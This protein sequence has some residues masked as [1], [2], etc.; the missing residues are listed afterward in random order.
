V[1]LD[2]YGVEKLLANLNSPYNRR[3]QKDYPPPLHGT[4]LVALRMRYDDEDPLGQRTLDASGNENHA[5]FV[6]SGNLAVG[7]YGRCYSFDGVT[8]RGL[9]VPHSNDLDLSGHLTMAAWVR[10]RQ[11]PTAERRVMGRDIYAVMLEP[12]L[13]GCRFKGR[14]QTSNSATT[15][16]VTTAEAD[17]KTWQWTHLA[18][19]YDPTAQT[20][21]LYQDLVPIQVTRSG[22]LLA[23][24]SDLFLGTDGTNGLVM[25]IKDFRLIPAALNLA[26]LTTIAG[27]EHLKQPGND[28]SVTAVIAQAFHTAFWER[29]YSDL[30]F[31][32]KQMYVPTATGLYLDLHGL[33]TRTVRDPGEGDP[34]MRIKIIADRRRLFTG[35]T[36]ED[37]IEVVSTIVGSV[38]TGN[39][40]VRE[41]RLEDG[42]YEPAYLNVRFSTQFLISRGFAPSEIPD[43]VALIEEKLDRLTAAGVRV[44]VILQ[45]SA[46]WNNGYNWDDG[47]LWGS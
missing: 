39:V 17:F 45:S 20:L 40:E 14:V 11:V 10:I 27:T 24:V 1:I 33:P 15:P 13:T 42:T 36:V 32:E 25:D 4:E 26:Q 12:T 30:K 19:V 41:N 28:P 21:K 3:Q 5:V 8:Y 18:L 9:Q 2:T 23:T 31:V 46:Q 29:I 6:G 34:A 37:V 35:T 7:K 47:A 44:E 22:T 16:V 43:A 38:G